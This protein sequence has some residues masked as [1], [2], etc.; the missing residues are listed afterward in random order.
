MKGK[1]LGQSMENTSSDFTSGGVSPQQKR[2]AKK[3]L[4]E[5]GID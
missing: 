1:F 2:E 3:V 5:L 4:E